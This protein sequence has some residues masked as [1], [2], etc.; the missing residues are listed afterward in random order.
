MKRNNFYEKIKKSHK[1]YIIAEIGANHN[2]D[3]EIAKKLVLQAKISGADCAKFQSWTT[4]SVF[5]EIKYKENHFLGDDYRKRKDFSLKEMV[6]KFSFNQRKLKAIS[7]YCKK[8]KIDFACTPFTEKEALFL[9]K[10]LKVPFIKVASMDLDNVIFIKYI[11]KFKLPIIIS[12]GFSNLTDIERAVEVINEYHNDIII[13]HCVSTYPTPPNQCNLNNIVTLKNIYK[14]PIGFSDHSKGVL[15]PIIA[16]VLGAK[17]IEKHFTLDNKMVGWDHKM[18][19]TPSDLRRICDYTKIVKNIMGD[20][21]IKV[22]EKEFNKIEF[23][24]SVVAK[25]N[26]KRGIRLKLSDLDFKRPGRG[27][28]PFEYKYIIGR[29]LKKNISKDELIYI[30]NLD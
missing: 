30:S 14:F 12:T 7:D 29:K 5:A 20:K 15:A 9:V 11:A 24:R 25:K 8:I 18:S 21:T 1:P 17:V 10:K 6:R 2:G 4:N 16:T 28:K 23:R 26:L 13:L 19:T 27:I 3:L 22:T